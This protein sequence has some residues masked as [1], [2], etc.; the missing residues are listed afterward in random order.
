MVGR[1]YIVKKGDVSLVRGAKQSR[2]MVHVWWDGLKIWGRERVKEWVKMSVIEI[3]LHL[4]ILD[5][6]TKK[7]T[8]FLFLSKSSNYNWENN[9][10]FFLPRKYNLSIDY[11]NMYLRTYPHILINKTFMCIWIRFTYI[12]WTMYIYIIWN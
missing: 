2:T 11:I 12:T 9:Y 1:F 7:K 3:L 4:K 8:L 5:V 6:C 10:M